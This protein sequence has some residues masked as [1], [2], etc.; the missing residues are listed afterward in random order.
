LAGLFLLRQPYGAMGLSV[1]F[2]EGLWLDV[3]GS[4]T[5]T[6]IWRASQAVND[7]KYDDIFVFNQNFALS[8]QVE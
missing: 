5:T 1:Q 8:L 7:C 6:S 3:F 2:M 4:G